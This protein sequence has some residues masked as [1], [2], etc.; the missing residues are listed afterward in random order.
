MDNNQKYNKYKNRYLYIKNNLEGGSKFEENIVMELN[1]IDNKLLDEVN[2]FVKKHCNEDHPLCTG[3][4]HKS[5]VVQ[6]GLSSKCPMGNDVHGEHAVISQAR[7]FDK[8]KDNY[9]S[10]VSMTYTG[11]YKVKAPCGICRELL[12]YHYP[13]LPI[14]VPNPI[15]GKFYKI[16]SK[17]LLPYPYV[18]T[19]LPEK[20][21]L[22]NNVE[23]VTKKKSKQ[24]SKNKKK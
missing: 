23:L 24:K 3:I 20:S 7:I 5:G 12:R 1:E 6:F 16:I 13:N 18:S 21:K 15:T 9:V 19:K 4:M 22:E 10:L 8:E 14:I 2:E 17:N 11:N